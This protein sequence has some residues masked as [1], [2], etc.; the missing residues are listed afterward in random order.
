MHYVIR[1]SHQWQK[2]KFCIT[3]YGALFVESV[4]VPP[5]NVK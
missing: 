4:L 1:R 2:D 3:C 5:E